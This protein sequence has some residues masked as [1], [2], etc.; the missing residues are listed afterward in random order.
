V[1]AAQLELGMIAEG[2]NASKCIHITNTALNV[3]IPIA[4]IIY[5]ILWHQLSPAN[6]FASIENLL[7]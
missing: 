4:E 5:N 6:G 2:Y 3:N 7:L 1:K